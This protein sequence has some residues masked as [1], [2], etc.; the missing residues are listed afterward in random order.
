[1]IELKA[2]FQMISPKL[3]ESAASWQKSQLERRS[4]FGGKRRVN[5]PL[6]EISTSWFERAMD[7]SFFVFSAVIKDF[8]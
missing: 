4:A 6:I 3:P 7:G 1:V 2:R 8:C 5:R